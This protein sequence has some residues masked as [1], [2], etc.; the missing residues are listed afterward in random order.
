MAED[1]ILNGVLS[2]ISGCGC[3]GC[4]S[5]VSDW[6]NVDL[7]TTGSL[8]PTQS[9]APSTSATKEEFG[10]YLT[11]GYWQDV[12]AQYG[13]YY[14]TANYEGWSNTS[15]TFS[16][17]NWYS[18]AEKS[19]IR[20]AFSQWSDVTNL[21]F[22]EVSSGGDI[23]FDTPGGGDS[24][25]AYAAVGWG[26]SGSTGN[27]NGPVRVM[28][29]YDS[30]GFG[31]D[32]TDLGDYALMTAIHEIGH[33][34][35]LGHSGY[36]NAGQGTPTYANDAQW[37]NETRQY[38][39]MS[40]WS[41]SNSGA[42]HQGE[43]A[44][45]PLL[46]DIYAIQ[47]LYG[48][49]TS[50]RS[51]NTVY[52]FNST[53]G[54]DQFDFTIN[55]KPVVAIWDGGGSD[56]L[57]L[58]GWS[59]AQTIT[60]VA[61]DFSNI[62]GGI[63]NLAIAYGA[64]IENAIGGSGADTIYGNDA[65]NTIS[66]GAGND[67]LYGSI[68]DDTLDG[69]ADSDT[70]NY[71]YTADS[72]AF[73]FLSNTSVSITHLSLGFTDILN[74][75]ENY[76]FS[77]VNYTRAELENTFSPDTF[78]TSF[79]WSGGQHYYATS[80]SETTTLTAG[81]IGYNTLTAGTDVATVVR[82]G[83]ALTITIDNASAPN[84]IFVRG[85]DNADTITINGTHS[86]LDA[87][88]FGG[89]GNDEITISSITG[90][91]RLYG[92]AG[93]DTIT[94]GAGNDYIYGGDDNDT[95]YGGA[96]IDNLQGD[97][98]TDE[99]NGGDDND[100]L[101]GG[102][103]TDTLNGDAGNDLLDGGAGDDILNGGDGYDRLY[104]GADNDTISGGAGNDRAYGG[105]GND[106]ISGGTGQDYLFG[107]AGLDTLYGGD[108]ADYL[109]GGTGDD[110]L[111]GGDGNDRMSGEDDNDTLYGEAGSDFLFGDGG[112]D[113]L[114]GG[115]GNDLLRG[116]TGGDT[117]NGEAHND[118]LYGEDGNDT[119]NGGDGDDN[120]GGGNDND[121]LNGGAGSDT[122]YGDAGLDTLIGGAGIDFLYGG[123]DADVF[124]FSSDEDSDDRIYDFVLGTDQINITDLL[125]GYTHGVSDIDDFALIVH[126]GSRF[127]V[128]VDSNGG[129]DSF[130]R[131]ARVFTDISDALGAQ[132]LLDS[133]T[134]I[135]NATLI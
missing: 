127:D 12:Y 134:L 86:A 27:I 7:E 116:G 132:D 123:A 5:S 21:T 111:Y 59:M 93:D 87:R 50:T 2:H 64:I 44:S 100:F 114:Y 31:S 10:A 70:V 57:D 85:A 95:L 9:S 25:R 83:S 28:I 122:L 35:G 89:G 68:G 129:A 99:L 81:D 74:N 23:Y 72:F 45:T 69:G 109:Y 130:T 24:G 22:T 126:T 71:S 14:E 60:L 32:P 37:T 30:G 77:G 79:N 113:T 54:V 15:L 135:A 61:G 82:S 78:I 8:A 106:G 131:V 43:Y 4:S 63:G 29:D 128:F 3:Y 76:I 115:N 40:Y 103:G 39:L 105:A 84:G 98:G 26:F 55:I 94:A 20:D 58:S 46:M 125:T 118:T 52:G 91:D 96:G 104:G 66:G 1:T 90:N 13:S 101:F 18:A 38:S 47:S 97:A 121:T 80:N 75:I 49:N 73:D 102:L 16:I 117:L 112:I 62:G 51:G 133:S 6:N 42:Y 92:E 41:A 120:M 56:T 88:I 19:G 119:L 53:A 124:G 110:T 48:A 34:L 107:E 36:Y 108:Q 17:G 65:N 33:A 11:D 67:L